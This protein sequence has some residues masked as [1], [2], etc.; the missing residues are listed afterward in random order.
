[1]AGS[2]RAKRFSGADILAES[3]L[4]HGVDTIFCI[5]GAGN[6]ALVDACASRGIR[7]IFSHHEQAA[8]MEAI[9]FAQITG[10]IGVAMVTTGGGASNSVTGILSA[11]LDSIPILVIAGNESSYQIDNMRGMR[12]YGVQGFDSVSVM[13][14]ICK[15]SLR[16]EE[17]GGLEELVRGAVAKAEQNR[18]G[19][20]FFEFPMN[21]QRSQADDARRSPRE[22]LDLL[23]DNRTA[24]AKSKSRQPFE[25][26]SDALFRAKRP[27]L[28][29]GRGVRSAGA[30]SE[31]IAVA[32]RF[33]IPF[34]LSWSALDFC[35][36]SHPL[37]LGR[38]GIYG[39]RG[40]NIALQKAD[41]VLT[42]GTRLAI[43]QVG[44]D[45]DDFARNAERWVVDVDP[46]ELSKF[47][48]ALWHLLQADAL[49]FLQTVLG[50]ETLEESGR[51]FDDWHLLLT[52][53][54][55]AFPR[56]E[57]VGP[58]AGEGYIHSFDFVSGL[59]DVLDNSAIIVTDVGAGLLTGH[60]AFRIKNGQRMFTSQGLGEMG[61]GL[62]GAIGAKIA[63]PDRMVVCLNT[64]GGIMFNL[65]ELQVLKTHKLAIKLVIFNNDGYA[66]IRGSQDNLF[67]GRR[68]GSDSGSD[69][70]FPNFA[71][72]AQTFGLRHTL[73]HSKKDLQRQLLDCF[74]SGGAELIEV[75][76][77]PDQSYLPR[78]GTR[79][80][81]DGS[82]HS[83]P[84]E[85]LSP[86][87]PRQLLELWLSRE[88]GQA[89][90]V[91]GSL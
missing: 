64:D 66:M 12:A 27:I 37:N 57:Q 10:R 22:S 7:F 79:K 1:V 86:A 38:A 32:E 17:L 20:V 35:A 11:Y 26:L 71:D 69:I 89:S 67:Q 87:I 63:A 5:T 75:R 39:D 78:L 54:A 85:D 13:Q 76:M 18:P 15:L 6:L 48:P 4:V 77:S 49:Q 34:V 21:L 9:G 83:P 30:I 53:L 31:A 70:G 88:P 42:V 14:P 29:F 3:L 24:T 41:F 50:W 90:E 2:S 16:V 36:D 62:P 72:I 58:A 51:R 52:E 81:E 45:R 65:Q 91:E 61:F 60:Y 8:V 55:K 25:D 80:N 43:P 84:I 74:E 23:G 40:V 73:V 46:S 33:N 68:S 28:Y 47:D 44:Y 56:S 59:S 82:L 19:P